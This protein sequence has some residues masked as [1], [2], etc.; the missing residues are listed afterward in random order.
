MNKKSVGK[1]ELILG[2]MFS[3]KSSEIIRRIN[4]YR[5]SG[6]RT[7]ALIPK[8]DIRYNACEYIRTH[9]ELVLFV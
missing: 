1:I 9:D 7:I 5:S 3:G 8:K 2:P 6:K 4:R